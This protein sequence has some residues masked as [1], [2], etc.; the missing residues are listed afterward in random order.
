MIHT[1]L[2]IPAFAQDPAIVAQEEQLKRS[3]FE[4]SKHRPGCFSLVDFKAVFDAI[5]RTSRFY[6]KHISKYKNIADLANVYL[7]KS[8][9]KYSGITLVCAPIFSILST[10][11]CIAPKLPCTMSKGGQ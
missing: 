11:V 8:V 4:E 9:Y 5:S 10:V 1:D 6:L 2:I 3:T 7:P